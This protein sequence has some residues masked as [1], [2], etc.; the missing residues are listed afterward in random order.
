MIDRER[1][2]YDIERCLSDAPYACKDCSHYLGKKDEDFTTIDCMEALLT[3][4][5]TLLY[6]EREV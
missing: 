5:Y 1:V 3:E 4:A 6:K 2:K